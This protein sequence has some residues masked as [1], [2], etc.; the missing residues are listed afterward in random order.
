MERR[1]IRMKAAFLVLAPVLASGICLGQ[2]VVNVSSTTA[3][4]AV[5]EY[6][7]PVPGSTCTI[8]VSEASTLS[9]VVND[10]N[11]TIFPGSSS[12]RLRPS[13]AFDLI[14]VKRTV[15]IGART[16]DASSDG[17]LYSRALQANTVHYYS[18]TCGGLTATGSFQTADPPLGNTY[19]EVPPFNS[20]GFGNYAWP[21][22]DWLNASKTYIDPMTGLLLKLA[23]QAPGRQGNME[24]GA[25]GEAAFKAA[26]DLN[27]AWS[28]A[29]NVLNTSTSGPFATYSG[30]NRDPLFLIFNPMIAVGTDTG[31]WQPGA[32]LD[33]IRLTLY[34]SGSGPAADR[35]VVACLAAFFTPANGTCTSQ[36]IE[37]VMPTGTGTVRGPA[38]YPKL[39]FS[40]WNVG[41]F[42]KHVETAVVHGKAS[43]ANKVV[44]VN[45]SDVYE[46]HFIPFDTPAGVKVYIAGSAPA[47]PSNW[48]T[49]QKVIEARSFTIV[50]DPGTLS[51]AD[52]QFGSFGIRIRK[53]T[54]TG[55][56]NVAASYMY[57][58]STPPQM[59]LN[60]V[61]DFCSRSTV[62][63]GYAA[64]GVTPLSTPETGYLCIENSGGSGPT[65]AILVV[66]IP[67]T[68]ETRILSHFRHGGFVGMPYQSFSESDP[69]SL[70]SVLTDDTDSTKDA[71]Y[72]MSYDP[73]ACH[74]KSFPG[75]NYRYGT[76][77]N[78]CMQWTNLT[79]ASENKT[80]L[81]Q[82]LPVA[83]NSPW[84]D[85]AVSSNGRLNYVGMS[86]NYAVF[87]YGFGGKDQA[88]QD[89]PCWVARIDVN[90]GL[91][92]Q[93][94]DSFST[95][96]GRW[97]GCH[98]VGAVGMGE[99]HSIGPSLLR[100][101]Q[102][103]S[104]TYMGGPYYL[105]SIYQAYKSGSWNSNTSLTSSYADTCTTTDAGMIAL[106]AKGKRCVKIRVNSLWPYAAYTNT[107]E[108]AKWPCPY[109]PAKS[110]PMQIAVG[111]YFADP[112]LSQ[113]YGG[114]MDGK[115]E[116]MLITSISDIGGGNF[117][118]E[119][120]RW[121]TC[122]T[123]P[124]YS[125]IGSPQ[126]STHPNGWIGWITG[127]G[128][129]GGNTWWTRIGE[130]RWYNED[131]VLSSGHGTMGPG[132]KD[133]YSLSVEAYAH[134]IA[135]PMPDQIG[136]PADWTNQA[137]L[138]ASFAGVA[139]NQS[140]GVESYP[141]HGQ[142]TAPDS[143]K[144]WVLD[145]RHFNPAYG[146]GSER[147]STVW[148]NTFTLVSGMAQVYK[149]VAPTAVFGKVLPYFG[150]AGP[151]LLKDKSGPGSVITDADKWTFCVAYVAGECRPGSAKNDVF[152]N[153]PYVRADW[154]GNCIA[155]TYAQNSLCFNTII[156]HGAWIIQM[157]VSQPDPLFRRY[158]RL[159][160]GFTGPLRQYQ[161]QSADVT[162]DGKWAFLAP[163]WLDGYRPDMLLLKI[164]PMPAADDIDRRDYIRIR[165]T[166]AA[167]PLAPQA[168]IRFGY[169]ENGPVSSFF[170]TSRQESCVTDTQMTPFAYAQTDALHPTSCAGGCN[171]DIP[172][173]PGRVVYYR[174]ERMDTQGNV[175][176]T[177][178]MKVFGVR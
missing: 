80:P 72:R 69:L 1:D 153:A 23:H 174:V 102:G 154:T 79:P 119:L 160:M 101:N 175:A 67:R 169:A 98:F 42:L 59:P 27:G 38:T 170:C 150:F 177:G 34:G 61:A 162:P 4:Q 21:S 146:S 41:R 113:S 55:S 33:D 137:D 144:N 46:G 112:D 54:T 90:T 43:V 30:A 161:F 92:A 29:S 9:P 117:E 51:N 158:R 135:R 16:S 127:T 2:L 89:A 95:P 93:V 57:A 166:L 134:R 159:T 115:A 19:P 48:C 20:A 76:A 6:A 110:C 131:G 156:P 173:I 123:D 77:P 107:R 71:I 62:T 104:T 152:M 125:H 7:T 49:F 176:F 84:W 163:G 28:N 5:L 132:P 100:Y 99:W 171:I 60:G 85:A 73:T 105:R 52:F 122:D 143:E 22:L 178:P 128:L 91:V 32:T 36:E 31:S 151:Y 94:I 45:D 120:M 40:G 140:S 86:G 68:G 149:V 121:A 26:I 37:I 39:Q 44:T 66:L 74:W 118:L 138:T 83:Q 50:E 8:K 109:D 78:D 111:D 47:C 129:C 97:A 25:G 108:V 53:K 142:W 141:N 116:K 167:N 12:D 63:V 148:S 70:F 13:T 164:P 15:T 65:E 130:N 133:T 17:K 64:D 165:E 147:P 82:F 126:H 168:R 155:N 81:Q 14:D 145:F 75:D 103:G 58:W 3:T 11:E 96:G 87:S 157:D 124:Y 56:V 24:W 10:V 35:T 172:A 106:G 88:V 139:V 136:Q 114:A 18:V